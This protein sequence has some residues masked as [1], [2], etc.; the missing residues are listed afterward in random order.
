MLS[1]REKKEEALCEINL[2]IARGK[3]VLEKLSPGHACGQFLTL[4]LDLLLMQLL[5]PDVSIQGAS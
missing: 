2:K 1:C 5:V 3:E 4:H